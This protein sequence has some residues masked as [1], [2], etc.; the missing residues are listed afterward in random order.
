M[1]FFFDIKF[2]TFLIL[3]K[4]ELVIIINVNWSLCKY[5][6]YSCQI[7]KKRNFFTDFRKML[8]YQIS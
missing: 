5:S 2:E 3:R 6:R 4:T 1:C 7:K 8:K